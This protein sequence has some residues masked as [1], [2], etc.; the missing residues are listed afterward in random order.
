M[1]T[2]SKYRLRFDAQPGHARLL[3][4]S[5]TQ[6][7][8]TEPVPNELSLEQASFVMMLEYFVNHQVIDIA[9]AVALAQIFAVDAVNWSHV[10]EEYGGVWFLLSQHDLCWLHHRPD[11]AVDLTN[12]TM[13]QARN[14]NTAC[15]STYDLWLEYKTIEQ[16]ARDAGHPN[17]P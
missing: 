11:K 8:F 1:K 5:I 4:A 12:M 10:K 16:E 9:R 15:S 13:T 6:T 17:L 2:I 3:C 14:Y 7:P